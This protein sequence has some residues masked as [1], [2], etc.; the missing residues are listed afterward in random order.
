MSPDLSNVGFPSLDDEVACL[1][2]QPLS[3]TAGE[4]PLPPSPQPAVAVFHV[5]DTHKN[6]NSDLKN[7]EFSSLGDEVARLMFKPLSLLPHQV[8]LPP[9]PP[10][11]EASFHVGDTKEKKTQI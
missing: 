10:P 1:V 5:G 3:V 8:P 7:I 2:S 4:V 11:A 9:S 6:K